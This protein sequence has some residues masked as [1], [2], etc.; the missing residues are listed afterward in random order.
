MLDE[1]VAWGSD[2]SDRFQSVGRWR[3]EAAT[4]A[5]AAELFELT[6]LDEGRNVRRFLAPTWP[7]SACRIR[8]FDRRVRAATGWGVALALLTLGIRLRGLPRGVRAFGTTSALALGLLALGYGPSGLL[9]VAAGLTGG[10]V[11]LIFF[12]LGESLPGVPRTW[13]HGSRSTASYRHRE[14]GSSVVAPMLLGFTALAL[15]AP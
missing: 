2:S 10:A 8:L 3:E 9:G 12:G 6:A 11:A 5:S 15:L 13:S 14:R 4:R 1:A 7:A